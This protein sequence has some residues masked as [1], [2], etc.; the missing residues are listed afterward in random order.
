MG[1]E[2]KVHFPTMAQKCYWCFHLYNVFL[3]MLITVAIIENDVKYAQLLKKIINAEPDMVC[4]QVFYNLNSSYTPISE[5]KPDVLLLD[6]QL[7]DGLGSEYVSVLQKISPKTNIIIN[8]SFDSDDYIF[9]SIKNGALGYIIKSDHLDNILSSIRDVY[10]GGAPM[11]LQIA[12]K[13][14]N[15]F[16]KADNKLDALSERENSILK[17]LAE[18]LLYKEIGIQLGITLDTV[19]K[20]ASSIYKKLQVNNKVAAINIYTSKKGKSS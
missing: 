20:H 4:D 19:K 5:L 17:L 10:H 16:A 9:D 14:L 3:Q 7:P 18:G 12:R 8:T 2:K 1:F 13:V 6:V 15:Y 11:S